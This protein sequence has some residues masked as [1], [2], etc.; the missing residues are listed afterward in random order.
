MMHD[1]TASKTLMQGIEGTDL[2][3]IAI[4]VVYVLIEIPD[5]YL[6]GYCLMQY[7]SICIKQLKWRANER[8]GQDFHN[9]P[10]PSRAFTFG[11]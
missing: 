5:T 10:Q 11:I 9:W 8:Y 4:D 6:D 3:A 1:V 7:I 2:F